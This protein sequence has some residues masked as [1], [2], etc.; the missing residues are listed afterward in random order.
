MKTIEDFFEEVEEFGD[1]LEARSTD[2]IH[3]E[4]YEVTV[5]ELYADWHQVKISL[6]AFC[7]DSV[8]ER[9]DEQFSSLLEESHKSRSSVLASA[10]CLNEV[11]QLYTKHVYPEISHREIEAGFVNSL[12]SDLEQIKEDKYH[13]YME[14]AIQCIQAGAYQG[15]AVM[16][17]QAGMYAIYQ[18]LEG[19]PDPI[20]VAYEKK[21]GTKPDVDIDDFWDFQK[22]KDE[23]ILILA[24]SVNIIDKSLKDMLMKDKDTRNKAAHPGIYDV[25]PNGTK[26]MLETVMQLLV[27][28]GL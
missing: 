12:V 24:E 6:K 10:R 1:D 25:G 14:E 16:G 27:E 23:H 4:N 8:I 20:H 17:W 7:Q 3:T 26:A 5:R 19:S 11:E 15:G 18:K 2:T 9:M 21:F 13:E 28:L 22:M